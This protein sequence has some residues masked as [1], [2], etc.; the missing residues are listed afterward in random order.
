MGETTDNETIHTSSLYNPATKKDATKKDKES[1]SLIGH[2]YCPSLSLQG[3]LSEV[4]VSMDDA[5][6]TVCVRHQSW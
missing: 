5:A 4:E 2:V 3:I 1:G 6:S